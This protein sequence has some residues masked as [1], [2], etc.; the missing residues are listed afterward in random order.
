M[1]YQQV[2]FLFAILCDWKEI[3]I[4]EPGFLCLKLGY[5]WLALPIQI[6]KAAFDAVWHREVWWAVGSQVTHI[7]AVTTL[8]S[9]WIHCKRCFFQCL[10]ANSNCFTFT[11]RFAALQSNVK[12]SLVRILKARENLTSLQV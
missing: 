8:R 2:T 7:H 10:V 6:F 9:C 5:I 4:T 11:C 3:L 1:W 12:R